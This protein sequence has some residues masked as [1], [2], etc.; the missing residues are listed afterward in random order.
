MY[1]T[2]LF[3]A[4]L[5]WEIMPVTAM[6]VTSASSMRFEGAPCWFVFLMEHVTHS[7]SQFAPCACSALFLQKYTVL[8]IPCF[9]SIAFKTVPA[10]QDKGPIHEHMQK[11]NKN[12]MRVVCRIQYCS[13]TLMSRPLAFYSKIQNQR[14]QRH[15][16]VQ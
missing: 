12:T 10:N 5:L 13:T 15:I 4:P 1:S 2:V 6:P 3:P 16:T 8:H 7:V 14:K 9:R 11:E